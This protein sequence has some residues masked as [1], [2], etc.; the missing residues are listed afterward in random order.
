M[1]SLVLHVRRNAGAAVVPTQQTRDLQHT[2]Y[3][4]VCVCVCVSEHVY[5]YVQVHHL[6]VHAT[7]VHIPTMSLYLLRICE[8]L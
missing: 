7:C 8:A 2:H 3:V 4:L 1:L 6:C 5:L